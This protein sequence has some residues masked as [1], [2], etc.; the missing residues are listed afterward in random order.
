MAV[1]KTKLSNSTKPKSK[2]V[3]SGL[4]DTYSL[5]TKKAHPVLTGYFTYCFSKTMLRLRSD[6]TTEYSS[7]GLQLPQGGILD[8]LSKSGP[9]NQIALGEQIG[10]DKASMVKLIDGLEEPGYVERKTHPGDRRAKTVE[11][12]A[13]GKKLLAKVLAARERVEKDFLSSLTE[14]EA[15]TFRELTRKLFLSKFA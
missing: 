11:I 2:K 8:I 13:K 15:A 4:L 3:A 14:K 7:L 12:T 9:L 10:I 6:L 1:K 5:V